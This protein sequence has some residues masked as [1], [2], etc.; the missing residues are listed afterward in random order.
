MLDYH[1]VFVYVVLELMNDC[2]YLTI[3]VFD[4]YIDDDKV[5]Y[6]MT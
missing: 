2:S 3:W 5:M 4:G 6:R 1:Y